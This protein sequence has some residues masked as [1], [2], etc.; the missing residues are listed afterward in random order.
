M[1]AWSPAPDLRD[2]LILFA[3]ISFA[4]IAAAVVLG[5][6]LWRRL[7]R[8]R[9]SG[10]GFWQT[11][12]EV[13]LSLVVFI[14]LLDLGLET[15]SAPIIWLLLRR[16]GLTALREVA[17]IEALIPF[18]GPLPTMT[19]CWLLARVKAKDGRPLLGA[20]AAGALLEGEQVA[21]GRWRVG[22]PP[23]SDQR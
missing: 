12:R 19:L 23:P 1:S 8:L 6:L 9:V 22:P 15:F 11:L 18:T 3:W 5:F 21:P 4:S 14:D 10:G 2:L 7:R 17:T 16:L 13:P 20:A